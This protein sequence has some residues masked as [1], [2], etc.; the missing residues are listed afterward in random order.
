MQQLNVIGVVGGDNA[1]MCHGTA[2][3]TF[4]AGTVK[5]DVIRKCLYL[6]RNE[7]LV[8]HKNETE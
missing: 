1:G 7:F 3:L 4:F 6:E 5:K 8:L 2:Q